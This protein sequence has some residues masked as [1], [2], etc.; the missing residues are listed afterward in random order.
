TAGDPWNISGT[1]FS[2]LTVNNA[3]A[4][5]QIQAAP[6]GA[7]ELSNNATGGTFTITTTVS[8]NKETSDAINY[9]A[10]PPARQTAL[11]KLTGVAATVTGGGTATDPWIISGTG[12]SALSVTDSLTPSSAKNTLNAVPSG[13]QQMSVSGSGAFIIQMSVNQMSVNDQVV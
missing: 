12:L 5:T 6:A 7:Y 8:G 9:N 10:T 1:G 2:S 3:A 11:N 4:T 13:A